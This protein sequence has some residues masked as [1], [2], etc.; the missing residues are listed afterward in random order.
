MT[1]MFLRFGCTCNKH[2]CPAEEGCLFATAWSV[3][4]LPDLSAFASLEKLDLSINHL[5]SMA[6]LSTLQ[7]PHL[8][9]LYLTSNKLSSIEVHPNSFQLDSIL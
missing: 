2:A 4:Q 9:E 3:V 8:R 6:T 7:A 1:T 5:R